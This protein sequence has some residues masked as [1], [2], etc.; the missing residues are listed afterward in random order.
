M[1]DGVILIYKDEMSESQKKNFLFFFSF[2]FCWQS[3]GVSCPSFLMVGGDP[4]LQHGTRRL[5]STVWRFWVWGRMLTVGLLSTESFIW[6]GALSGAYSEL[7]G[8]S[9]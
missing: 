8:F 5:D 4:N 2:L 7:F 1:N 3:T 9:H 6:V